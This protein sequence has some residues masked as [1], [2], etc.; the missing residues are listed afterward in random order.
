MAVRDIPIVRF[1]PLKLP[2]PWSA[3]EDQIA[4]AIEAH[5]RRAR[6]AAANIQFICEGGCCATTRRRESGEPKAPSQLFVRITSQTNVELPDL[7]KKSCKGSFVYLLTFNVVRD[8]VVLSR[9]QMVYLRLTVQTY[10]TLGK[11][12]PARGQ[13]T[14]TQ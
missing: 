7:H 11:S 1:P 13:N 2:L 12:L 14:R 8:P 9:Q 3:I 10:Q 4:R 5:E 6:C